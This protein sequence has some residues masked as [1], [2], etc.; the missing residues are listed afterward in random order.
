L[1]EAK[2]KSLAVAKEHVVDAMEHS[3]QEK[4]DAALKSAAEE[5]QRELA[6]KLAEE[7]EVE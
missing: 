6:A 2:E 3:A 4:L 1:T 7:R 5:H